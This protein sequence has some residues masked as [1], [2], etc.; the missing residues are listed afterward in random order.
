MN[1][2]AGLA[3]IHGFSVEDGIKPDLTDA[4]I[5]RT[6]KSQPET[7]YLPPIYAKAVRV[8]V[9]IGAAANRTIASFALEDCS[10]CRMRTAPAAYGADVDDGSGRA[11]I[12]CRQ[13]PAGTALVEKRHRTS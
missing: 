3:P 5:K 10:D 4:V 13:T 11:V 8:E 1:H 9:F 12:A 7:N 2:A 6:W